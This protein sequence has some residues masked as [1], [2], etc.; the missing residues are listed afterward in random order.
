M[1][2]NNKKRYL[3]ACLACSLLV[4]RLAG[5]GYVPPAQAVV[6]G[7]GIEAATGS[8]GEADGGGVDAATGGAVG[9]I[10]GDISEGAI[11]GSAVSG[12]A[13]SGSAVS[14]GSATAAPLVDTTK[15][16]TV[17]AAIRGGS[18]RVRV[19]W[20]KVSNADGYYVYLRSA[21]SVEFEKKADVASGSAANVVIKSLT[22]KETYYAR[23]CAYRNV[24][25]SILEGE[26]SEIVSAKTKAVAATSKKAEKYPTKAKF[27]KSPAYKKF[28]N[29]KNF[30]NYGKSFAIPGMINTNAAGF[31]C[32]TMVPQAI[33]HAG[34]YLLISAYDYTGVEYSVIHIVSK[35]S[36]S[37]IATLVL[38]NKA[39]VQGMAYD[40]KNIWVSKGKNAACFSYAKITAAANSGYAYKTLKKYKAVVPLNTKA[41]YM[42]YYND[43]LWVGAF[44]QSKSSMFGYRINNKDTTPTLTETHT[45]QVPAKT[46]GITFKSDGTML[47][48]RSYR[49]NSEKSGYLSQ[50]RTYQ[51]TYTDEWKVTK[52]TALAVKKMPPMTEGIAVYGSYTYTLFSSSYYKSCVYPVDRVIALKTS[53]LSGK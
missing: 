47:L 51:P 35:A 10:S 27:L 20:N 41:S 7:G 38:P 53:K 5:G 18:K 50:I 12:S 1:K 11:S 21:S 45:M 52:N 17:K 40:G 13:V 36:K 42:G 25:G 9:D 37:Y 31:G 19:S 6:S 48:S 26:L 24:E 43:T 3:V 15:P 8:A 44:S 30:M 4:G 34:S 33:C 29:M 14:G 32:T 49:T 22:Q 23:V 16:D 39:K 2:K 46:Q 28:K